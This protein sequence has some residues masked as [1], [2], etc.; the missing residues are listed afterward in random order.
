MFEQGTRRR[1]AGLRIIV[2][3]AALSCAALL[4][5]SPASAQTT[6]AE[7]QVERTHGP[8]VGSQDVAQTFSVAGNAQATAIRLELYSPFPGTTGDFVVQIF[9][10]D[11][12]GPVGPPLAAGTF[13]VADAPSVDPVFVTVNFTAPAT[14]AAG[15]TYAF[16]V[17]KTGTGDATVQARSSDS[18]PGQVFW[19]TSGPGPWNA[20]PTEDILFVL[21]GS[22]IEP[23]PQ[24][25]PEPG[26]KADGTLTLDANKGKVEKGR[27]V[28]LSGQLDV[29]SNEACEP[30][31]QIQIQRRLK[32]E[33]DSKF[34]PFET[35][36][37]DATG[38]F[39]LRVKVS[40]TH[41]Y[42]AVISETDACDDETS[43]SVKVR[44]QKKE[45]A[46]EA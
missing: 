31:R 28:T 16:T 35:V 29:P 10:A 43:N 18:C 1:R 27:K 14:L 40:R 6:L 37:T 5:A 36:S 33:D 32:S 11:A 38:N 2:A 42:R 15:Q 4:P 8:S 7:C 20:S 21:L 34:A 39:S 26:P 45:A 22:P 9:A 44:A 46:Q 19:R 41:F 30:G 23:E 25:Q 13:P 24:P 3:C 17:T 12:T